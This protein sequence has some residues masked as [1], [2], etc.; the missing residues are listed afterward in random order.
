MA[1]MDLP[2]A[3]LCGDKWGWGWGGGIDSGAI[4]VRERVGVQDGFLI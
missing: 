1:A 4:G 2:A 3:T